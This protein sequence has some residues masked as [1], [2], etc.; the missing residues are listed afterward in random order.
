MAF[1]HRERVLAALDHREPDRVPTAICGG[2]Y[3]IVDEIYLKLVDHFN[4][5]EPVTPFRSG[6]SISY[7]DDRLLDALDT[8]I[9]YV[10]P[11]LMP[12]SPIETGNPANPLRDSFGQVWHKAVPYYFSGIGML[13]NMKQDEDLDEYITFPEPNDPKWMEGVGERAKQLRETTDCFISMRMVSSHGPFQTAC[14]LRGVENFLID[15]SLHED[16]AVELLNRIADLQCSLVK[17]ALRAG[18]D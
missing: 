2:S 10:F 16:F 7:M 5:G 9:R 12:N 3:G 1:T 13:S 4:L 18:G 8:D 14:D 11:N 6:H 17:E 15:M